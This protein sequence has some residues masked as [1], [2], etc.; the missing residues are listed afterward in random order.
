MRKGPSRFQIS[1]DTLFRRS[2]RFGPSRVG[3]VDGISH[4]PTLV[5]PAKA[6]GRGEI[7]YVVDDWITAWAKPTGL[8]P[9]LLTGFVTLSRVVWNGMPHYRIYFVQQSGRISGQPI[10]IE[11][12][13]D[14]EVIE[15]A[16]KMLDGRDI[17]IW[18]RARVVARLKSSKPK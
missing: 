2:Y 16:R 10:I 3:V 5:R 11:C 6:L 7:K 1:T 14:K 8:G 17:E 9:V 12:D 18:D 13:G 15:K 4:I